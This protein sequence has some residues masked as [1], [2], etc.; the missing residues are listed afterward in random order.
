MFWNG[1]FAENTITVAPLPITVLVLDRCIS[2]KVSINIKERRQYLTY[3]SITI[4]VIVTIVNLILSLMELPLNVDKGM[5][6]FF[7]YF[8]FS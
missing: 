5:F 1:I 2:L 6:I 3:F 4:I 8:L 7:K